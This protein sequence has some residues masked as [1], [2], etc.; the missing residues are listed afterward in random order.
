[1]TDAAVR[2][3]ISEYAE[4]WRGRNPGRAARLFA[5]DAR[6]TSDPY[7]EPLC[8]P[9]A[10]EAYWAE[11]LDGQEDIAFASG[12]PIVAGD[13]A[14]VE[15]WVSFARDDESVTLAATLMLRFDAAGTYT[16]L[17]EYW[18]RADARVAPPEGWLAG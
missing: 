11:A 8:G 14:A 18:L 13:R 16:E 2:H 3:W 1:M 7:G 12:P 10:I 9:D 6:Y 15:W 4:A 5:A 17:R